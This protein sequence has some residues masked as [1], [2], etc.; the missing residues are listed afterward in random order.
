VRATSLHNHTAERRRANG[1]NSFLGTAVASVETITDGRRQL[2]VGGEIR[3]GV[4]NGTE[5]DEGFEVHGSILAKHDALA[6]GGVNL[7][8]PTSD[9]LVTRDGR[10]RIFTFSW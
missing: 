9:E 4:D 8:V 10:G 3:V 1:A 6:V 5:R 7:G 2:Y